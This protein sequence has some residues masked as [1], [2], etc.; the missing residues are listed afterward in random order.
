MTDTKP[1]QPDEPAPRPWLSATTPAGEITTGQA[2]SLAP[3]TL[4]ISYPFVKREFFQRLLKHSRQSARKLALLNTVLG[5][6]LGSLPFLIAFVMLRYVPGASAPIKSIWLITLLF[7][8]GITLWMPLFSFLFS[9]PLS[10]MLANSTARTAKG[11]RFT[12]T[13]S[14]G[15]A[16]QRFD[17]ARTLPWKD[18]ETIEPWEGGILLTAAFGKPQVGVPGSAFADTEEAEQFFEAA[19]ILWKSHGDMSLVPAETRARFAPRPEPSEA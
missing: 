3:D 6:V 4:V 8:A 16:E 14:P 15:G 11:K 5:F 18:V 19:R 1:V 10:V 2:W 7:W 13:L 12:V 17:A 9:Y